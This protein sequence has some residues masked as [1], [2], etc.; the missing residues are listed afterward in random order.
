M[1]VLSVSLSPSCPFESC[2]LKTLV[3]HDCTQ[4]LS[5]SYLCIHRHDRSLDHLLYH[6]YIHPI[7]RFPIA[8]IRSLCL[9]RRS[10][11]ATS[12]VS[13]RKN[14]APP[15]VPYCRIICMLCGKRIPCKAN[16][17]VLYRSYHPAA[18]RG[19]TGSGDI[20]ERLGADATIRSS[21]DCR[22]DSAAKGCATDR[23]CCPDTFQLMNH[24]S[25]PMQ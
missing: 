20:I 19:N 25:L 9:S 4:H 15:Q 14:M 13:N 23:E 12:R 7:S 5:V 2:W 16:L 17:E 1:V 6:P 11:P 18:F 8:R 22:P 10:N 24:S 3:L 21:K